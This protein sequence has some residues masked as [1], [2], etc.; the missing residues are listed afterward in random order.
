MALLNVKYVIAASTDLYFNVAGS[1]SPGQGSAATNP[2]TATSKKSADVDGVRFDVAINSVT[3]LPRYYLAPA[4][5]GVSATPR[6]LPAGAPASST[7]DA[8]IIHDVSKL[9]DDALVEGLTGTR[10]YDTR[11]G[12]RVSYAGDLIDVRVSP[13]DRMR[14]VVLNERYHPDWRAYARGNQI[15]VHPTNAVMMGFEVPAGLTDIELRFVPFSSSETAWWLRLAA[16]IGFG[17]A[18]LGLWHLEGKRH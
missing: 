16:C 9:R 13:S 8:P 5:T 3:P 10:E 12:L 11:G 1:T 7:S 2:G 6:L 15:P 4:V 18:L 17:V 14:F